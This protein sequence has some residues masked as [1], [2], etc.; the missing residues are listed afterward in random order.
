MATS[1]DQEITTVGKIAC[2]PQRAQQGWLPPRPMGKPHGEE[3]G[4]DQRQ[5]RWGKVDKS[6]YS[7]LEKE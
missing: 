2:Y 1:R 3:P 6:H 4:L 5:R 7:S